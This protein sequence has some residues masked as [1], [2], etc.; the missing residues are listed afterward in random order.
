MSGAEDGAKNGRLWLQQWRSC[1]RCLTNSATPQ[2]IVIVRPAI[3]SAA[4]GARLRVLLTRMQRPKQ[5]VD[6]RN[7]NSS[8]EY[9]ERS[10]EQ[11]TLE[12]T[13]VSVQTGNY[14]KCGAPSGAPTHF[15]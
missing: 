6:Q 9:E 11:V 7:I 13:K 3:G 10:T 15:D 1:G 14:T 4:A 5:S 2:P 12:E 8:I